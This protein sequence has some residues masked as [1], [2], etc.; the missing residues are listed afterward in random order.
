L[1]LTVPLGPD[2][3]AGS[4]RPAALRIRGN[5][6]WLYYRSL[7][8]ARLFDVDK[9]SAGLLVDQG[10]AKVMTAS[11]SGFIGLVDG[12]EG[13]H[14]YTERKAVRIDLLVEDPSA[15][16]A[17]LARRG[18]IVLRDRKSGAPQVFDPGGYL[19]RFIKTGT[20]YSFTN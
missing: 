3:A 20:H 6:L 14:P 13:L 4:T 9:F 19:F 5:I 18:L 1:A 15:W 11:P 10:F 16:A 12:A 17:V 2:P 7:D 8:A